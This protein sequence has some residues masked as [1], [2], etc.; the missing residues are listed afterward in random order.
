M[1]GRL[2]EWGKCGRAHGDLPES[3]PKQ[4]NKPSLSD[5]HCSQ[6]GELCVQVWVGGE[7]HS[8][9]ARATVRYKSKFCATCANTQIT[10]PAPKFVA[11]GS[12]IQVSHSSRR[13]QS[14]SLLDTSSS[15]LTAPFLSNPTSN[16][17]SH[18]PPWEPNT[19]Y[20]P[21]QPKKRNSILHRDYSCHCRHRHQYRL[22][23]NSRT[24][25][26]QHAP[27][28]YQAYR[29]QSPFEPQHLH[30]RRN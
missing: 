10:P 25:Q 5:I 4:V 11:L 16:P 22:P 27:C 30:N 13:P 28:N 20:S 2:D 7:S 26:N 1:V 19:S 21:K 3:T 15:S 29:H 6:Y 12:P 17:P 23:I 14:L 18:F 8:T 9:D 24:L